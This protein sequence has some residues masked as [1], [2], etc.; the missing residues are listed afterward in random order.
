MIS[1]WDSSDLTPF[2]SASHAYFSS[3]AAFGQERNLTD[4]NFHAEAMPDFW[5][6]PH[7][8]SVHRAESRAGWNG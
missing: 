6:Y 8:S 4:R 3:A 5:A 2:L 7:L 1:L